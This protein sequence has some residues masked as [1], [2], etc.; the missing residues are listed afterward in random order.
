MAEPNQVIVVWNVRGIN[1][2]AKRNA[3]KKSN[4]VFGRECGVLIGNEGAKHEPGT[5][6]AMSRTSI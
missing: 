1:N 5:G 6:P 4:F 2:L 3:I